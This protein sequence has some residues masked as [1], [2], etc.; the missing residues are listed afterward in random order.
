MSKSKQLTPALQRIPS[1]QAMQAFAAAVQTGSFEQA[2]EK[3]CIS[4]SAVS[5]RVSA[6]EAQLGIVLLKRLSRGVIPTIAGLEYQQK[7]SP[8]LQIL[9]NLA[10]HK[11]QQHET[12]MLK[13]CAPPTFA[14]EIIIPHLAQFQQSFSTINIELVLS[15]PYL[16]LQPPDT[17]VSI[18]GIHSNDHRGSELLMDEELIVVCSPHFKKQEHIN[19]LSDLQSK[20]LIRSPIEP[21]QTWLNSQKL[22]I[23]ESTRSLKLVDTGLCLEAAASGLGVSL[24]RPSMAKRAL[25]QGSLITLFKTQCKPR[26]IY[27]YAKHNDIQA[28]IETE[29]FVSWLSSVCDKCT[30]N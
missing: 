20:H 9:Q 15:V 17:D 3:L 29:N 7:I 26:M 12:K 23:Q 4:S 19:Q 11:I 21:W 25:Q 30:R 27:T 13:V 14:R 22:L 6:L 16:G 24:T 1:V 10:Q 28:S 5:K 2:S 8:A 18:I